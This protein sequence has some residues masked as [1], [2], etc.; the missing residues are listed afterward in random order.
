V[1]GGIAA[2]LARLYH[3]VLAELARANVD[4]S[5]ARLRSVEHVLETLLDGWRGAVAQV[6]SADTSAR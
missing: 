2:G 3:F 1:G 5:A 4:G 6:S